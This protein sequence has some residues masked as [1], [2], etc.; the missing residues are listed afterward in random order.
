VAVGSKWLLVGLVCLLSARS[1]A[2]GEPQQG[3]SDLVDRA[4]RPSRLRGVGEPIHTGVERVRSEPSPR[5]AA[6]VDLAQPAQPAPQS[7]HWLLRNAVL[8]GVVAG[9]TVGGVYAIAGDNHL[10][11]RGGSDESCV[12]YSPGRKAIG[13]G[14]FA[15][16]GGVAGY[17]VGVM[18]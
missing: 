7:R 13:V 11:C 4:T 12:L 5:P 14:V 18:W 3:F 17:L 2:A 16:L 6:G 10:F 1:T 15:A 9:A 8:A